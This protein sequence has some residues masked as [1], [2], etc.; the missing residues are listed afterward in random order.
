MQWRE[1]MIIM[2]IIIVIIIIKAA[3]SDDWAL[4]PSHTSGC[5]AVQ[6]LFFPSNMMQHL[7]EGMVHRYAFS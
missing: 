1:G 5:V 7:L 4:T 3:S 2:I 6:V